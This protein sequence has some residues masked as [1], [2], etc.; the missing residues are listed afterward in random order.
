M[1]VVHDVAMRSAVPPTDAEL[2]A[3]RVLWDQGPC[4]VR[5]VHDTL[6]HDSDVGYTTTLKLLQN[7]RA[8]RLVRRDDTG[9][10]HVFEAI[11][12]EAATM[13]QH[14]G[15]LVDATFN[16]SSAELAMRALE[17]RPVSASELAELKRMVAALKARDQR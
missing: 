17:A 9:K 2:A 15:R 12:T 16:G 5:A 8:K 13:R 6:Y 1:P 14:V 11:V 3:L 4:T 7:L 10:Q